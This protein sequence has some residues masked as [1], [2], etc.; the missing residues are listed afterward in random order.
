MGWATE[1]ERKQSTIGLREIEVM[2]APPAY[3]VA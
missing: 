3:T 1:R 2:A